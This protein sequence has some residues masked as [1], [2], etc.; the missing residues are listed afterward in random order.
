[1]QKHNPSAHAARKQYESDDESASTQSTNGPARKKTKKSASKK[2]KPKK[3]GVKIE[4]EDERDKVFHGK[5][6]MED[7]GV[8]WSLRTHKKPN[9]A[10]DSESEEA[11][12]HDGGKTFVAR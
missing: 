7:F 5:V 6:K 3:D 4:G 11:A 8:R 12:E 10:E 9:F 1:L 2:K